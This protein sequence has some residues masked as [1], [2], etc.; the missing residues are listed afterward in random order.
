MG[1]NGNEYCTGSKLFDTS[2]RFNIE[3]LPRSVLVQ[4]IRYIYQARPNN[5]TGILHHDTKYHNSWSRTSLL[6][7]WDVIIIARFVSQANFVLRYR[8][9]RTPHRASVFLLFVSDILYKLSAG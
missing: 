5:A 1:D 8:Y 2:A 6:Y 7:H 9:L 3:P 4:F